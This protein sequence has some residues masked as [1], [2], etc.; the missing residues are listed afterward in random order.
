MATSDCARHIKTI[1]C[2]PHDVLEAICEHA[3]LDPR[4]PHATLRTQLLTT[5]GVE[6]E[7]DL[8]ELSSLA[9]IVPHRAKLIDEHYKIVGDWKPIPLT[10]THI[11]KTLDQW[12]LEFPG[13]CNVGFTMLN[14]A[15][16]QGLPQQLVAHL[17]DL[18]TGSKPVVFTHAD[19][20]GEPRTKCGPYKR[21]S[22]VIN[23][24]KLGGGGKHW[25]CIFIDLARNT[26][27]FF[28][29]SGNPPYPEI[30]D[31]V[32]DFRAAA[33]PFCTGLTFVPVTSIRHQKGGTECGM[34]CLNYIDQR[35]QGTSPD[36][37][38]HVEMPDEKMT[39]LRRRIFRHDTA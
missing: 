35:L 16:Y 4:T 36:H 8:F 29:S 10:N 31:W 23:S 22:L 38:K 28:N 12:E 37:F 2:M 3:K 21:F 19:V 6:S 24:D 15:T 1:I 30:L 20:G 7:A 14:F 26:I 17:S 32:E 34:Y 5:Y 13:Y 33:I 11:D 39:A 9:N 27:E 18:V 25:T